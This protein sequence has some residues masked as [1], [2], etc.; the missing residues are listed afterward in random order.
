MDKGQREQHG[1][2][3]RVERESGESEGLIQFSVGTGEGGHGGRPRTAEA[4]GS[5][6]MEGQAKDLAPM[7]R[8]VGLHQG[9][10]TNGDRFGFKR[11][12]WVWCE[13]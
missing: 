13:A 9:F 11:L 10:K 5:P 2:R 3:S 12:L 1:C 4:G 8:A 6:S 7:L